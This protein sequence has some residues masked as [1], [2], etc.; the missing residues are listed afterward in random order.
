[1]DALGVVFVNCAANGGAENKLLLTVK[2][3]LNWFGLIVK[4]K[5]MVLSQPA[6]LVNTCVFVPDV[7]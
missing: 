1:M 6:T 7:V 3:G 5:V 4:F 2:S